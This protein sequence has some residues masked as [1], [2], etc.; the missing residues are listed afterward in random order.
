MI[1]VAST[2]RDV[3]A[4][5]SAAQVDLGVE[6]VN[7]GRHAAVQPLDLPRFVGLADAPFHIPIVAPGAKQ[8]TFFR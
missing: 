7:P 4:E 3:V 6:P 2:D 1:A 5:I 8:M